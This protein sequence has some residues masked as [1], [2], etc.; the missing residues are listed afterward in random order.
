MSAESLRKLSALITAVLFLFA[1]QLHAL[2]AE[3]GA[4]PT[5]SVAEGKPGE[6]V[7]ITAGC[8]AAY[9]GDDICLY[10]VEF[11]PNVFE[12]QRGGSDTD[13]CS[14]IMDG[15]GWAD[16]CIANGVE[17]AKLSFK[18]RVAEDAPQGESLLA[19]TVS[20]ANTA[21]QEYTL[22][23]VVLPPPSSDALLSELST[24]AGELTPVFSAEHFSYNISVPSSTDSISFNA[25][26][27]DGAACKVNRR[28]L[29]AAGSD[30]EILLTV[31]AE[32]GKT[33]EIYSV[34]VHREEKEAAVK[35]AQTPSPTPTAKPTPAE[36]PAP[37]E[38]SITSS[39]K[40][41]AAPTQK[42]IIP[43]A[44]PTPVVLQAVTAPPERSTKTERTVKTLSI[45]NGSTDIF[46]LAAA[47][48][49]MIA[50]VGVSKPLAHLLCLKIEKPKKK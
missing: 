12:F 19:V 40:P 48:I 28:K 38:A 23:F 1:A 16:L 33:K 4:L 49:L 3:N 10:H 35:A 13:E 41:T 15:S 14:V 39:P 44:A 25:K 32:D 24:D 29:G 9:T 36:T 5:L 46:P 17:P 20:G 43:T 45:H 31:T 2:A 6:A 26:A 30:T 21:P 47:A 50:V 27:P 37:V 8:E 42:P 18:F 11:D 7:V 34:N 22:P